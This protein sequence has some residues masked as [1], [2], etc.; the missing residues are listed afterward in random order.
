MRFSRRRMLVS[1]GALTAGA[2]ASCCNPTKSENATS[3]ATATPVSSNTGRVK[4]I[5]GQQDMASW[6]KDTL[7]LDQENGIFA[8]PSKVNYINYVGQWLK[9]RGPLTVPHSPQGHP[10]IIQAGA[11]NKGREFAAKWAELIFEISPTPA[12]MKSYYQDVKTRMAKYGRDPDTCKILSAVMPFVGETETIAQEK[13][14][15][16][17]E[18][19]HPMAGLLTMSNHLNVNLSTYPLDY[20]VEKLEPQDY[21][22]LLGVVQRLNVDETIK[23]QDL[24][25]IYG[26]SLSVPQI[27]GNPIQV[28]D[29]L[30]SI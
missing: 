3:S 30:M 4:L 9:S 25:K 7:I 12:G 6:E 27:V 28:A 8:D 1:L 21:Q 10:V 26:R 17:N 18:L 11:S 16:H 5:V 14:A 29:K 19:V 24:G 20:S 13:Q 15:F 22:K 23:L 2:I